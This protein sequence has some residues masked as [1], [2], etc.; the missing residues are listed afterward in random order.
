VETT[1]PPIQ[2]VLGSYLEAE[3]PVHEAGHSP[4]PS[5][6][7]KNEWIYATTPSM[8]LHGVERGNLPFLTLACEFAS[9]TV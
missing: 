1:Q 2:W 7:V 4:P 3:L 9:Q 6:K 8:C 5:A